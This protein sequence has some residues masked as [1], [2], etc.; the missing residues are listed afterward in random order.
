VKLVCK[1]SHVAPHWLL[2]RSRFWTLWVAM[3]VRN[4][5]AT[6]RMDATITRMLVV[7]IILQRYEEIVLS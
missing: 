2:A 6:Q 3:F 7:E 4:A 1:D 5:V